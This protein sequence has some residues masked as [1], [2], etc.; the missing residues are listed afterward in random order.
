M[1]KKEWKEGQERE[2]KSIQEVLFIDADKQCLY[3]FSNIGS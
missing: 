1:K 3:G 2:E